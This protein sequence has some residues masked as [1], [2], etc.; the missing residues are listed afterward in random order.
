MKY[1][2]IIFFIC[3]IFTFFTQKMSAQD[4]T[5]NV[6]AI[7]LDAQGNHVPGA[8]I[9]SDKDHTSAI[10]NESGEFTI[11]ASAKSLLSVK[12]T[13]YKTSFVE[14]KAGLKKVVLNST[15]SDLVQVA[16]NQV[17]KAD[18]LGGVS[19]LNVANMLE[20]NYT[21]YSL[22]NLAS[23][24]PGYTGN[25]WGMNSKLVLVDGIPR[26]EYNVIPSEIEQITVLKSAAAV[27]LYGSR[28][29]KGVVSITTKRG[30]A[31]QNKFKVR[32]NTGVMV[33]KRYAQYLG[34][35]D[36]MT[37]YNEALTNDNNGIAP[38][39]GL[40]SQS[41]IAASAS[42]KNLTRYPNLNF[43][44]SDYLK[45]YSERSEVTTEYSGGNDRARFYVNVGNYNTNTLMNFGN[46]KKEGENRFNVRGNLDLKLSD[47]I[48]SKINTSVTFY[49][50][51]L[52]NN[53]VVN[54]SNVTQNTNTYWAQAATLRPNTLSPLIP[55]SDLQ[56]ADA[57]SQGY[58]G[59]SSFLID[60]K[61]L[62][63]GTSNQATNAFA[64]AYTRGMLQGT[65][66]KY[67][68]DAS[69]NFNLASVLKGLSFD[70]QFGIDYNTS[71]SR[72][73]GD[74][75]YA[76]YSPKWNTN[77]G[78]DTIKSLTKIGTD[79]A[80]YSQGLYGSYQRQTMFFSGA[81]KYNN[82]FNK[83]HN[84]SAILLAHGYTLSESATYHSLANAN[85][86]L[87]TSYNYMQKYYVDFTGNEVHSSRLAVGH[88]NAFSP[89]VSLG[90][91]I[92]NEDFLSKSD[93]VNDLKLTVSAGI[94]NTDLDYDAATNAGYYL[95]Q[96]SY[97]DQGDYYSWQEGRQLRS[98]IVTRG[99]N[100]NVGYEKRKDINIGLETSLFKNSIQINASYF[101]NKLEGIPIQAS[102]ISPNYLVSGSTNFLPFINYNADQRN[103]FDLGVQFNKRIGKVDFNVGMVATYLETSALVRDE[104]YQYTYQNRKGKPMDAI[105]GL[106]SVGFY[107]ATSV[108]AI[109]STKENPKPS[110]GAVKPG[111]IRY[112]DINGDGVID[113]QD[114][115]Y[116]GKSGSY[117]SPLTLGLN[118][119]AKWN[120][121][122]LF[123]LA[124]ST[125]GTVALKNSSYYWA[126]AGT[127]AKYSAAMLNR[128][129]PATAET[130][131]YPRLTATSGD[132]NYRN[133]DFWLYKN[134]R[135]NLARI[136][137]SY[138]IPKKILAKTFI[139]DLGIY[140]NGNDLLLIAK[141]KE[142]ME[143]NIGSAPQNRY[144]SIGLKA[145][146]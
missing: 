4:N 85:L 79:N 42:G 117:G 135:I 59:S 141:E 110:F 146:F 71:Y 58:P 82:T 14:A 3:A 132:N 99:T 124:N 89:T 144:Y 106:K 5:I 30:V 27:A 22:D 88:R 16:F 125:S 72:I 36:Y 83:V 112:V 80:S 64:D 65:T 25:T 75:G 48:T 54:S 119:T 55:V 109:N 115:V 69:L 49:D 24:I 8:V 41:D 23:F 73:I 34:S 74:N 86:G 7:V 1:I 70:T 131:T 29:S 21:T 122:S 31:N 111:D 139:S 47:V 66:R 53:T 63:G 104:L 107:D 52:V 15:K 43:Y 98:T 113:N 26:D 45:K 46:G 37:L 28:A 120:N 35:S 130:A 101:Y 126:T 6:S 33:P 50:N 123:V 56:G 77:G 137:F 13:G 12:A 105:F 76:V 103:G 142:L 127:T 78:I 84:V 81:F 116:L 11:S 118:V 91:R 136:Q 100:I 129:T 2:K 18:L 10:A 61:Y 19:S 128:W 95:Y 67:Q 140:I 97:T 17:N 108:A 102:S 134:D 133:S 121:F 57:I 62:L 92:S 40:Y 94:L 38:T 9:F 96:T 87:Q 68:F 90:W 114:Q 44:S 20:S 32:V 145:S 143:T 60:G 93:I 138:D 39:S 51:N